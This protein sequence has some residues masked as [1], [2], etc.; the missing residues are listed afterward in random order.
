[1]HRPRLGDLGG[2]I[3]PARDGTDK[4]ARRVVQPLYTDRLNGVAD[5]LGRVL[6]DQPGG[7]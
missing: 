5:Q 7:H 4:P 3:P 1:M 2:Q 6:C